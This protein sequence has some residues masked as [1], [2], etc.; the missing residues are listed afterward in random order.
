MR[1]V[2]ILALVFLVSASMAY[3][4]GCCEKTKTGEWCMFTDQGSCEDGAKFLPTTCDQTSY[5][6]MG[7]CYSS[8]EGRCFKN[9]PRASC[10]NEGATWTDDGL[11]SIDQCQK[12]CCLLGD[13][14]FFV[15]EV[16]CKQVTSQ[17]PDVQMSYDKNIKT[18]AECVAKAK[19]QEEGCCVKADGCMFTARANCA[20]TETGV[21]GN[22]T[23]GFYKDM[24]CSNDKLNC[25]CAKEKTTGCSGEDVFWFDSCGNKENVYMGNSVERKDSSYNKGYIL[26]GEPGCSAKANDPDCGNCDYTSGTVCGLDKDKKMPAGKYTCI[27]LGCTETY[28]D[29]LSPNAKEGA[30]R[31]NGESWCLYDSL[32]GMGR[33]AV[34]S[35]HYRHLC[36]NGEELVEPCKDFR[37]ELCIQGVLGEDAKMTIDAM[38]EMFGDGKYIEAACRANRQKTCYDCNNFMSEEAAETGLTPTII[39]KRQKCCE[40]DVR[41]CYWQPTAVKGTKEGLLGTCVPQVP[42]GL[43]FWGDAPKSQADKEKVATDKNA[44]T[45]KPA[46]AAEAVC[47]QGDSDCTVAYKMPGLGRLNVGGFQFG[48]IIKTVLLIRPGSFLEKDQWEIVANKQCV[49]KGWVGVGNSVCKSLGDCGA[50]FNVNGVY[51]D[52]GYYNSLVDE[53]GFGVDGKKFKLVK[54]E[55]GSEDKLIKGI[56]LKASDIPSVWESSGAVDFYIASSATMVG[57]GLLASSAAGWTLKSFGRGMLPFSGLGDSLTEKG[58][59]G[60]L[61]STTSAYSATEVSGI[62]AKGG[63]EGFTGSPLKDFTLKAGDKI[64]QEWIKNQM[65]DEFKNSLIKQAQDDYVKTMFNA[66]VTEAGIQKIPTDLTIEQMKDQLVSNYGVP[67]DGL[68]M[69][70]GKVG[71]QSINSYTENGMN[72]AVG[73]G[74]VDNK[75]VVQTQSG[76]GWASALQT[77]M[78][79]RSAAQLIDM[80]ATEIKEVSYKVDCQPWQPPSGGDDCETCNDPMKPCSEYKCMSL[81]ASCKLVNKGSSN[82]TCVAV[83]VNDV[84]APIITPDKDVLTPPLKIEETTDK[85]N[86]G[87]NIA[88]NIK[89]FTPITIGILADEPATCKYD[90]KPGTKYDSMPAAF[91][92]SMLLY[93]QSSSFALTSELAQQNVT[94]VNKGEYAVYI[95][96]QDANGNKNENDYFI[97]FTVDPTPDMTPPSVRYTSIEPD[98]FV[99]YN[100]QQIAFSIYVDEY[101]ECKWSRRDTD[102]DMME[103]AFHCQTE[104]FGQESVYYGTFEC[105]TTLTNLTKSTNVFFIRCRDKPGADAKD[106]NTMSESFK[107][108]LRGSDPL[109]ITS[110]SPSG[111]QYTNDITMKVT[112]TKGAEA[113]K[114]VCAFSA[115]DVPFGSMIAFD[116]TDAATHEQHFIEMAKG[117]YTFFISCMD[118]AGNEARDKIQF[119]VAVDS[120]PPQLNEVYID[121]A[122]GIVHLQFDE[123]CTCE[124]SDKPTFAMGEGSPAATNSTTHELPLTQAVYY[125]KC[126]DVFGNKG[127]YII[128]TEV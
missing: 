18:E 83:D 89:P 52:D 5:C 31:K 39:E 103:N 30:A 22:K 58:V 79:I 13:Q 7:C 21:V 128:Y 20:V 117:D 99:S 96:C 11:C 24:L 88:E 82:E 59:W 74:I 36:I 35:R 28:K 80:F 76:A 37:E 71:Q 115:T 118:K 66:K 97:K 110:T 102:Y 16:K 60:G 15:T 57:S 6:R 111:I 10:T 53:D 64:S 44:A 98:G 33:D 45:G 63:I 65:T 67:Q 4:A 109:N 75:G 112:T 93:K 108:S 85:G 125:V 12:G 54:S 73:Q 101:A 127:D 32:P 1:K 29:E 94:K 78:W 106:R 91:G 17:Y 84:T 34:G 38:Q 23:V 8:D 14:A 100:T 3:A 124:Y 116:K 92:S 48:T 9:T 41:D 104:A 86:P 25:G 51:T 120:N 68:T 56:G 26:R 40:S 113:G 122:F 87:Y 123:D 126:A 62:L 50:Y 69:D 119:N 81:G 105:A 2:A 107:F 114:A 95:R 77:Y 47:N 90:V 19:G 27:G 55:V 43:K 42:P 49:S 70:L 72:E 121:Q 61:F 46:T